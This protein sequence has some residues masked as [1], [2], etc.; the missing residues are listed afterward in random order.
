MEYPFI[1][2]G[3][4][5]ILTR[6]GCSRW[7][8]IYGLNGTKLCI[9]AKLN[10]LN[11]MDL[12]LNDPQRL[13]CHEK[14]IDKKLPFSFEITQ[15]TLICHWNPTVNREKKN[16]S[17]TI[18]VKRTRHA[19]HSWRTK[20]K[21]TILFHELTHMHTDVPEII[22]ISSVW[23]H[24]VVRRTSWEWEIIRMDGERESLGNPCCRCDL[25]TMM[26]TQANNFHTYVWILVFLSY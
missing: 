21:Q 9:Y 4:K 14:Q 13:I 25:M 8:P 23:T 19:G 24:D 3:K 2:I 10:F 1:A 7:G 6:S 12:E 22:Y 5:S 16:T 11:K 15:D 26:I 20:D 18:E 17:K